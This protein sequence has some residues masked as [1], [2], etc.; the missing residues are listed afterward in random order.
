MNGDI[1]L[2]FNVNAR[3]DS[4]VALCAVGMLMLSA[5]SSEMKKVAI[6]PDFEPQPSMVGFAVVDGRP[7]MEKTENLSLW[8]T[9]CNFMFIRLGDN[10]TNPPR[11]V[12]LQRDLEKE[13]GSR[14]ANSTLVVT[15]YTVFENEHNAGITGNPFGQGLVGAAL[16][17][18]NCKKEQ[19]EE[20]G[21]YEG[22]EVTTP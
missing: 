5:C 21:W 15:K 7:G 2:R 14:L 18:T 10:V 16:N 22:S 3:T 13:L 9:S 12:L 4:L 17:P 20:A 11:L 19:T 6:L 8:A 1:M